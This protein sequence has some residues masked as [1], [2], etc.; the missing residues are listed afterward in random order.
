MAARAQMS[1]IDKLC[2]CSSKLLS[3][4]ELLTIDIIK[5][6]A[7]NV[8]VVVVVSSICLVW[9]LHLISFL[10]FRLDFGRLDDSW[11]EPTIVDD[12]KRFYKPDDALDDQVFIF[13]EDDRNFD[14]LG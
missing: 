3:L 2:S 8:V 1:S 5:F 13:V 11:L 4:R 9:Y 10:C 14:F 7:A 12:G 6:I